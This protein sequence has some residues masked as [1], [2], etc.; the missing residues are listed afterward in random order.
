M[1]T[2]KAMTRHQTL[3]AADDA[4]KG[5]D[6]SFFFGKWI[7]TEVTSKGF[8]L[9]EFFDD[10]NSLIMRVHGLDPAGQ[11]VELGSVTVDV[12]SDTVNSLEGTKFSAD[13]EFAAINAS[14][15]GW[16]KQGVLVISVFNRYKEADA[17]HNYFAREFFYA[18]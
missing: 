5:L 1:Q 3:S 10:N 2:I 15:H 12:F 18:A 9:V 13:F 14:M 17:G 6:H 7:N 16:V 11:T 4:V 8:H